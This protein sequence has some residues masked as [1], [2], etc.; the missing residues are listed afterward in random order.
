MVPQFEFPQ[1]LLH[2]NMIQYT[3][4]EDI[5]RP[6]SLVWL[7]WKKEKGENL[8]KVHSCGN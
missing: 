5:T 3:A 8:K 7:Y 6:Y 1:Y 4:T 2:R